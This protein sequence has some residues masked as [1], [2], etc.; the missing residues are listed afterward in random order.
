MHPW[1]AL[2]AIAVDLT[3]SLRASD[4]YQRL[5]EVV[6]SVIPCNATALLALRDGALHPLA[7]HGLTAQV[8]GMRFA[9]ADHPRLGAIL[10][11]AKPIR[12]PADSE[13]PDPFDGFVEGAPGAPS[14]VHDCLGC[15]LVAEGE[16]I[17]VLTADALAPDAFDGFGEEFLLALGAL[18]GAALHTA[19]L[20]ETVEHL[21]EQRGLVVKELTRELGRPESSQMLGT[22]PAVERLRQEIDIVAGTDF[23]VLVLGETGVGKELAARAIHDGSSR[24]DAPLIQVNCAA[25]PDGVIESEL[26]GHIRG[27]FTGAVANRAGKFELAHGGTLFLDEIGELPLAAQ[28]KLL[29]A[30]QEGEVQRVGTDTPIQVNV[31]IVAATNRD[32]AGEVAQGRFRADL[33]HRLHVFP[34]R[35][36]PLRERRSDI[37]ILAG[38]FV[39]RYRAKLGDAKVVLTP[40]A[41][42]ALAAG[43][44]PGN[45]RELDHV[46]ARAVLRARIRTPRG[47]PIRIDTPDLD[48]A[49]VATMTPTHGE[50]DAVVRKIASGQ[51]PLRDA[52]ESLKY[53]AITRTLE[54]TSGN[55]AEAARRL[56]MDRSN[57]HH[58]AHRLGV[59]TRAKSLS[60]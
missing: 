24:R 27:A 35:V 8:L 26:F 30:I 6:R 3:E 28:A 57:L 43:D 31:R 46:I 50:R 48:I 44:W 12:F 60:R 5:L 21:A 29:R 7:V 36:P 32:L 49:E 47:Q 53:A 59:P 16:V 19:R 40:E 56:G 33:Y 18:A 22:S 38:F 4:R 1:P 17:G 41:I 14:E 34:L 58:M 45:V 15:P 9:P 25:L 10:D 54:E 37:A 55:W 52:I 11:S 2:Q 20:I 51:L 13:L 39:D 23:P 42:A